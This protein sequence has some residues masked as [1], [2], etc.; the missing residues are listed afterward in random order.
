MFSPINDKG[1]NKM[2]LV[3]KPSTIETRTLY[4][5][6]LRNLLD[7]SR[8][9]SIGKMTS[10]AG[11]AWKRNI[12]PS[13]KFNYVQLALASGGIAIMYHR[14]EYMMRHPRNSDVDCIVM[15]KDMAQG[16]SAN[17]REKCFTTPFNIAKVNKAT[18]LADFLEY[19]LLPSGYSLS[20]DIG[21][22]HL[23]VLCFDTEGNVIIHEKLVPVYD[24][25][26]IGY[27]PATQGFTA[28]AVENIQVRIPQEKP[29]PTQKIENS[30]TQGNTVMSKL[31]NIATVNKSAAITAAKLEAGK[32]ALKQVSKVVAPRLPLMVR[33]YAD[34]PMGRVVMANVLHF[35][36]TNYA[37]QNKTAVLVSEAAIESAM[38]E[39]LQS[40]NID[41]LIDS[42]TNGI[43]VNKFLSSDSE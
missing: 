6:S 29:A 13:D 15:S 35:V 10:V 2:L 1:A 7:G 25:S 30:T 23:D 4:K 3:S 37:S 39:M 22:T 12:S 26:E 38:L 21:M 24:H 40:F 28:C 34:T 43:D 18:E 14:Q 19:M 41:E 33:G 17:E 32:I 11:R 31:A 20:S 9:N 27:N 16:Y 36:V 8:A 42:V 5:G